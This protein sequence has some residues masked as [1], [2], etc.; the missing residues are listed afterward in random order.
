MEQERDSNECHQQ[1]AGS[2]APLLF[3][4]SNCVTG[5]R[6]DPSATVRT[7]A[8]SQCARRCC[9]CSKSLW[10]SALAYSCFQFGDTYL[11]EH[12]HMPLSPAYRDR[13]PSGSA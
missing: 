5:L 9:I 12:G 8:A 3:I 1:G 4:L 10:C 13:V 2:L 11:A 7:G 6:D